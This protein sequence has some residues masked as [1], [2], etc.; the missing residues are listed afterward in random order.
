MTAD[1][2]TCLTTAAARRNACW[3][4]GTIT[5]LTAVMTAFGQRMTCARCAARLD[6]E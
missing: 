6:E 5:G 1:A 4:C 3:C 2:P